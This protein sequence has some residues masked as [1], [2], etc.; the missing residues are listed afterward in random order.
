[1][2]VHP[3]RTNNSGRF[4]SSSL[5]WH[6]CW[7]QYHT[8]RR[9]S[10]RYWFC[11]IHMF[12]FEFSE[13]VSCWT[14]DYLETYECSF[15]WIVSP[16]FSTKRTV[17]YIFSERLAWA[18]NAAW[19]N[20]VQL[21]SISSV[22]S[23][24][25]HSHELYHLVLNSLF[26]VVTTTIFPRYISRGHASSRRTFQ[27]VS[28]TQNIAIIICK[29]SVWGS[30]KSQVVSR[31]LNFSVH[32]ILVFCF[33]AL[34]Q[35]KPTFNFYPLQYAVSDCMVFHAASEYHFSV[36]NGWSHCSRLKWWHQIEIFC[37]RSKAPC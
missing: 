27:A 19:Q 6:C 13:S 16:T 1:M 5:A 37:S 17:N 29:Q 28:L 2:G 33:N 32:Y 22:C 20:N 7:R 18:C 14:L 11:F 4:I 12:W 31:L 24:S 15:V 34:V 26:T 36:S 30:P 9:A 21:S 35:F 10:H 3:Q 23:I 8:L 25:P